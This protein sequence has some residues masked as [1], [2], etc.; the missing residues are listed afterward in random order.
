[1]SGMGTTTKEQEWWSLDDPCTMLSWRLLRFNLSARRL[2]LFMCEWCRVCELD[3]TEVS[4]NALEVSE[5]YADGL[6]S[7]GELLSTRMALYRIIQAHPLI[8]DPVRE[9]LDSVYAVVGRQEVTQQ[10]ATYMLDRLSRASTKRQMAHRLRDMVNI[11]RPQPTARP[12]KQ[13][14]GWVTTAASAVLRLISGHPGQSNPAEPKPKT[15]QNTVLEPL[16]T[17][18][19]N[20]WLTTTTVAIARCAYDERAFDRLPILADALQDAGCN[21]IDLLDHLRDPNAT[22]V[23]GCWALDLVLGRE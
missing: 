4:R 13:A 12:S 23:R 20:D 8:I 19:E 6:A 16:H 9:R 11:R 14:P 5:R 10:H 1:M 17:V 18:I 2:R 21:A 22:H 15:E 3:D 7:V